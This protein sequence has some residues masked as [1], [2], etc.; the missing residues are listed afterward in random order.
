MKQMSGSIGALIEWLRKMNDVVWLERGVWLLL[1]VQ[2]A[3]EATQ[4]NKTL[5]RRLIWSAGQERD[6]GGNENLPGGG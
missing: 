4:S 1:A 2:Q 3:N 5:E 6:T